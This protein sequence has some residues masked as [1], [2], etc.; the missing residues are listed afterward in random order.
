MHRQREKGRTRKGKL[1]MKRKEGRKR[2][3]HPNGRKIWTGRPKIFVRLH[4]VAR[5][6]LDRKESKRSGEGRI[7]LTILGEKVQEKKKDR[8]DGTQR[9]R[10][11]KEEGLRWVKGDRRW[12]D[13]K[14]ENTLQ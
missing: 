4:G 3:V 11:M 5:N 12:K 13:N 6:A 1:E 9:G 7:C 14:R 2:M 8:S 10:S